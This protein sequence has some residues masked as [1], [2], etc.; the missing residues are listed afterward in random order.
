MRANHLFRH[1][2]F[3]SA[4]LLG[5][6]PVHPV[7]Q[8]NRFDIQHVQ[9]RSERQLIGRRL[10]IV[11]QLPGILEQRQPQRADTAPGLFG[12]GKK[13]AVNMIDQIRAHRFFVI[14]RHFLRWRAVQLGN[15]FAL[16]EAGVDVHIRH[17]DLWHFKQVE[18]GVDHQHTFT[19]RLQ[20]S[21]KLHLTIT[22]SLTSEA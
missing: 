12:G 2:G 17:V 6:R 20:R 7:A 4:D 3:L 10:R 15:H 11:H 14:R 19:A 8:V 13:R 21:V 16:T 1:N 18:I 22:I 5:D 9:Q